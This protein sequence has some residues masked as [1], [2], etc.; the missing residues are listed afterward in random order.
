MFLVSGTGRLEVFAPG[1][2]QQ[3]RELSASLLHAFLT[4]F[5]GTCGIAGGDLAYLKG[6]A[7]TQLDCKFF[8]AF[9]RA[10]LAIDGDGA[11][12]GKVQLGSSRRSQALLDSDLTSRLFQCFQVWH[13]WSGSQLTTARRQGLFQLGQGF[14]AGAQGLAFCAPLRAAGALALLAHGLVALMNLGAFFFQLRAGGGLFLGALAG[15]ANSSCSTLGRFNRCGVLSNHSLAPRRFLLR[16][17]HSFRCPGHCC[18]L[19]GDLLL[20]GPGGD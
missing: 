7:L 16:A 18:L 11:F 15:F 9:Q 14:E 4:A 8:T 17:R 20:G 10:F 6:R 12:P 3:A 2:L 5:A 13:V 19:R 1:I